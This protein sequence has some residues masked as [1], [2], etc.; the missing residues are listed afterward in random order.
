MPLYEQEGEA[1]DG[2]VAGG[3]AA[4]EVQG[5]SLLGRLLDELEAE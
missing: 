3:L 5:T 1:V 4:K 2:V